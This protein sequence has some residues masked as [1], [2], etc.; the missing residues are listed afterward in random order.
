MKQAPGVE[1]GFAS[2]HICP[3]TPAGKEK[4]P[5]AWPHRGDRALA[6]F[7]LVNAYPPV[8]NKRREEILQ[9][10]V[11]E[12][13]SQNPNAQ[14]NGNMRQTWMRKEP[15]RK[16]PEPKIELNET[17]PRTQINNRCNYPPEP[18]IENPQN[19]NRKSIPQSP[20][21]MSYCHRTVVND[22]KAQTR[23]CDDV[24][25]GPKITRKRKKI[26]TDKGD[27]GPTIRIAVQGRAQLC[28]NVRKK[29]K[30]KK[31]ETH[32]PVSQTRHHRIARLKKR[33]TLQKKRQLQDRKEEMKHAPKCRQNPAT[34]V[35][36]HRRQSLYMFQPHPEGPSPVARPWLSGLPQAYAWG[37][38]PALQARLGFSTFWG[39][40][41]VKWYDA[42]QAI[43]IRGFPI[44]NYRTR[45]ILGAGESNPWMISTIIPGGV[46][47]PNV[48]ERKVQPN[49]TDLGHAP[50]NDFRFSEMRW[51]VLIF[52]VSSYFAPLRR[53]GQRKRKHI[54][55]STTQGIAHV[56]LLYDMPL[57]EALARQ[58]RQFRVPGPMKV[59]TETGIESL[60]SGKAGSILSMTA[61]ML[62][63]TSVMTLAKAEVNG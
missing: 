39:P 8:P 31:G 38:E 13:I 18:K 27:M 32:Q 22:I 4:I 17:I 3:H 28:T 35:S 58:F 37:D 46:S 50:T 36:Q 15:E 19:S 33:P 40:A 30:R 24:Q 34:I 63:A 54:S 56:S 53:L 47:I 20:L 14:S 21:T 57:F 45:V 26:L 43:A 16:P 6:V 49:V 23:A 62:A 42:G 29:S 9:N 10:R 60:G 41:G 48:G 1:P 12:E 5:A 61:I 7:M 25:K 11:W 59:Q 52:V 2:K 55:P 44:T 51:T